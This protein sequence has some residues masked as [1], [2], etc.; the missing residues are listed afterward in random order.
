MSSQSILHTQD[1]MSTLL[2]RDEDGYFTCPVETCRHKL[3][4]DNSMT[5]HCER[6]HSRKVHYKPNKSK[7]VKNE[8]ARQRKQRW[9][10]GNSAARALRAMS[11][12][13][14]LFSFQDARTRGMH[15]ATN[16]LVYTTTSSIPNAGIGV[17][18]SVD[19]R[20]GDVVTTYDGE[21]VPDMPEDPKY[22]LGTEYRNKPAWI[23]GL[24]AP[25]VGK[26]LGS[27]LNRAMRKKNF[28]KNCEYFINGKLMYIKVTQKIK[29][30]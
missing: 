14:K 13:R 21:V 6:N 17:F 2:L 15:E 24:R 25:E 28:R 11:A 10:A 4:N 1:Q 22:V 9:R 23:D 29:A 8:D 3:K 7:E 16:A 26:G 20:C 18:V 27:F 12:Q 19:M 30:H 5:K